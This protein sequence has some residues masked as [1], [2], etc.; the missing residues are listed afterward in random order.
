MRIP[1]FLFNGILESGKT[2]FIRFM[3]RKPVFAD[4]NKTVVICCEEGIEEYD[5]A[6][7]EKNNITFIPVED[8]DDF[9]EDLMQDIYKKYNPQR[10]IIEYN[11]M[12]DVAKPFEMELPKDWFLYEVMTLV[13]AETYDLYINNMR[14]IMLSHFSCTDL[15]IINRV[16]ENTNMSSIRGTVKSINPTAKLFTASEKLVMQPVKDE[17]PFDVK[18]D[19]IDISKEN[20]GLWYIDIWEHRKRYEN[21]KVKVRGLF[22]QE[23]TDPKDRFS[24][25]RFSMPCCADDIALMGLYCHNIG[26]PRFNNKDSVELLAEIHY[27]KEEV[28]NG[29]LG[30]VLYVKSITKAEEAQEDLV[31]FN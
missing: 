16:N 21:K 6:L 13:N 24:F 31:V 23:P 28:Y 8:E 27:E 3:L 10:L 5:M 14:S 30:P 11:G 29:D 20:Y 4:G 2:N 15:V 18:A 1:I 19:I 26:K 17:L 7:M 22:F 9:T 12:W 25:G